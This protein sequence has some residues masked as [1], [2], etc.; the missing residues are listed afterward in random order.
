MYLLMITRE[1]KSHYVYIKD[2]IKFMCNKTRC[3][4]KKHFCKYYLQCL[5]AK[6]FW[7]NIKRFA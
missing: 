2:F 6:K 4:N 7:K 3:K 5:V 1:N